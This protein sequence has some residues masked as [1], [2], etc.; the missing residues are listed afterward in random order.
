MESAECLT[1]LLWSVYLPKAHS[2]F[3][4][5][6]PLQS[7]NS[8]IRSPFLWCAYV[9]CKDYYCVIELTV[10]NEIFL[11]KKNWEKIRVYLV[12]RSFSIFYVCLCLLCLIFRDFALI[13]PAVFHYPGRLFLC[14]NSKSVTSHLFIWLLR[15]LT[16]VHFLAFHFRKIIDSGKIT[17]KLDIMRLF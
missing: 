17:K 5:Y 15:N 7:E 14:D 16:F 12:I 9:S 6:K 10:S 2:F 3:S 11:S 1:L 8:I 4:Y 13:H